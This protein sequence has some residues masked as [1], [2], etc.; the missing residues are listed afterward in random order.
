MKLTSATRFKVNAIV[1]VSILL[2]MFTGGCGEGYQGGGGPASTKNRGV[3][4]LPAGSADPL[5]M[6]LSLAEA[7]VER[8][9]GPRLPV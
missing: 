5:I 4:Q 1:S 6:R 2:T 8:M 7:S 3:I 9:S